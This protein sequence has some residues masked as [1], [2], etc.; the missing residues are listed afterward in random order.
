MGAAPPT[1]GSRLAGVWLAGRTPRLSVLR[2]RRGLSSGPS[3]FVGMLRRESANERRE[4]ANESERA[5][6]LIT[7]LRG[8]NNT[9]SFCW[10]K[11]IIL[12]IDLCVRVRLASRRPFHSLHGRPTRTPAGWP[13]KQHLRARRPAPSG[14][15]SLL[16]GRNDNERPARASGRHLAAA[17]RAII[18]TGHATSA[19]RALSLLMSWPAGFRLGAPNIGRPRVPAAPATAGRR[20]VAGGLPASHER[21]RRPRLER[22]RSNRTRTESVGR[23]QGH[24]SIIRIFLYHSPSSAS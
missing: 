5:F 22:R 24:E 1:G 19:R 2:R 11:S 4:R 3:P 9:P 16:M 7:R 14:P 15:L 12:V 8:R 6:H 18:R 13:N 17:E 20:L 21:R 10:P 23:R